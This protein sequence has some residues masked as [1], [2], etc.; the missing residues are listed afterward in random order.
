[1]IYQAGVLVMFYFTWVLITLVY[2]PV[3]IHKTNHLGVVYFSLGFFR[4]F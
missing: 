4:E 2:S 1:M 3:K